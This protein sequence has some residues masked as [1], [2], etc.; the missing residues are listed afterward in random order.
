MSSGRYFFATAADLI[1]GLRRFEETLAV[2]YV[3]VGHFDSRS[4]T[5]FTTGKALPELGLAA[6][7]DANRVPAFLVLAREAA[8]VC[9]EIRQNS[10]GVVFAIDQLDNPDSTVFRAGGLKDECVL[11]SGGIATTGVSPAAI[12]LHRLMVRTVTKGFRR[13]Q[14]FW[15][16]P[17]AYA[18]FE[19]GAKLTHSVQMSRTYDLRLEKAD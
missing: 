11:I 5:L 12:E 16:G 9:R 1:P 15:L 10:G 3:L 14:S 18:M 4:P 19:A 17:E 2:Q 7:G 8:V 6:A 13:V